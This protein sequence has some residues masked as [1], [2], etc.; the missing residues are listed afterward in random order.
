MFIGN[1]LDGLQFNNNPPLNNQIRVKIA[2]DCAIFVKNLNR[3]LLL[4]IQ[5]RVMN[6][7]VLCC[8]LRTAGNTQPIVAV[9]GR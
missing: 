9:T 4:D 6:G 8:R 3:M 2:K 5:M 1:G 7:D